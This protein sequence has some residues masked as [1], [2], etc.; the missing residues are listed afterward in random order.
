MMEPDE[1]RQ[2]SLCGFS[3]HG[4]LRGWFEVGYSCQQTDPKVG[5]LL[6]DAACH[7][8]IFRLGGL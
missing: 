1:W 4:V 2:L 8:L 7:P 3:D 5:F 6:R